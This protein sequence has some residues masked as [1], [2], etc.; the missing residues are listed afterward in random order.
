MALPSF[1]I[2]WYNDRLVQRCAGGGTAIAMSES[3]G[4]G[5][6]LVDPA[7]LRQNYT[8]DTLEISAAPRDPFTLFAAWFEQAVADPAVTE[9]NAMT[10]ATADARGQPSARIVLL[11]GYDTDGFVFYSN[12]HST[13]GQHLA[14]NPRAA[15]V[16]WWGPLERQVR[17]EGTATPVSA[18]ESDAYFHSRP[19]GS[20]IGAVASEQSAVLPDR[21]LLERR[22]EALAAR[23]PEAVPRPAYWGGYR[24]VP[25]M[26]E[27][28]QGRASRL[29]DRLR[30]RLV[31]VDTARA[32]AHDGRSG[33]ADDASAAPAGTVDGVPPPGVAAGSRADDT[34]GTQHIWQLERLSP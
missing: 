31:T 29:H 24:L 20:R 17:I 15:L 27:F 10:L 22:A 19:H 16:F 8:R 7:H 34:D 9:A 33:A 30:Y 11:K 5:A 28:W 18:E 14:G 1:A 3:E 23:Y 13:K 21:T 25:E 6:M 2:A 12:Y 4:L 26:I 32:A